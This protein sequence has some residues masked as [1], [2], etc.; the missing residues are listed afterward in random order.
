MSRAL[1]I[2]HGPFGRATLYQVDRPMAIHVH[3]EGHLI[4]H[5]AG[6]PARTVVGGRPC[7]LS[8]GWAAAVNPWQPH[9][10]E[11]GDRERGSLFLV[12]YIQPAWFLELSRD[13]RF[14]MRF[15]RSRIEVTPALARL[16]SRVVALLLEDETGLFEGYLFELARECFDRSW[17]WAPSPAPHEMLSCVRDFRLRN[18]MRLMRDRL[19][20]GAELDHIAREGGL[21]RPH[22][23][24]L[25]K[26]HLG[27][28]PNLYLN[29]LRVEFALERLTR[30]DQPV[31]TIGL[32]LGF[33]TQASFTRFFAA[34][35]GVPPTEY[36]RVA[37]LQGC[38]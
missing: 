2:Y 12:L 16:A 25:F 4:F 20:E 8:G 34:N 17:Q 18:C 35:V 33:S 7:E 27:I 1:A 26:Q 19:T 38:G 13:A 24:K 36:R 10:F 30:T 29:T 28:T 14:A 6:L 37:R 22:F 3:R 15:G 21:S 5:V 31:T 32:D 11:P 23:Y 9:N